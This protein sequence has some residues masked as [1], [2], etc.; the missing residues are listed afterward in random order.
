MTAGLFTL[1]IITPEGRL[2]LNDPE[3]IEQEAGIAEFD[4]KDK[5]LICGIH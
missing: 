4:S 5:R 2:T 3:V 1:L